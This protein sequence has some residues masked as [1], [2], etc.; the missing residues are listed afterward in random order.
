MRAGG[1]RGP[2]R[3]ALRSAA[4]PRYPSAPSRRAEIA[5]AACVAG[6]DVGVV[7]LAAAPDRAVEKEVRALAAALPE[8][9][10]LWVGGAAAAPLAKV[11]SPRGIVLED[12]AAYERQRRRLG[13]RF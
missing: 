12:D 13:A 1:R 7:G 6:V 5:A 3:G 11:V 4:P 2:R 8:G 10:D 9:V